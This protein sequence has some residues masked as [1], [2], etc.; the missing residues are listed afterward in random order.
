MQGLGAKKHSTRLATVKG[1]AL[2]WLASSLAF[3]QNLAGIDSVVLPWEGVGINREEFSA[4]RA[5]LEAARKALPAPPAEQ[6]WLPVWCNLAGSPLVMLARVDAQTGL[7][8]ALG[9]RILDEPS[10]SPDARATRGRL[11]RHSGLPGSTGRA[12]ARTLTQIVPQAGDPPKS[13]SRLLVRV[14][15]GTAD[16]RAPSQWGSLCLNMLLGAAFLERG[17][18]VVTSI[19]TENL[20]ALRA[21]R[22]ITTPLRR[23]NRSVLAT[24]K[25]P[26]GQISWPLSVELTTRI[27][28]GVFGQPARLGAA[29]DLAGAKPWQFRR[30]ADGRVEFALE[31]SLAQELDLQQK[32]LLED[33]APRVARVSGAW[34][35][36]D[37]GRAW[38]LQMD[39]RLVATTADG[40]IVAGHVVGFYGAN[41]LLTSPRG[42]PITEGAIIY[43]RKGQALVQNGL[44]FE[45]DQ[46]SYPVMPAH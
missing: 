8:R 35:W 33:E 3:A 44:S 37:R 36:V 7:L 27:S 34:A 29:Q 13:N 30:S 45:Y 32:S 38:G 26:P 24:W 31:T 22:G 25:S 6:V 23:P 17:I 16:G 10:E 20:T 12:V 9:H 18:D 42:F 46:T 41:E 4:A 5:E 2:V 39:D 11:S 14:S 28:D 15:A 1:A 21:R 43:V 40:E 19:G